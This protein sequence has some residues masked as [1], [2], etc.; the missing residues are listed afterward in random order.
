M[1]IKYK[2]LMLFGKGLIHALAQC[3]YCFTYL[4]QYHCKNP[5]MMSYS[6]G[7]KPI[8]PKPFLNFSF[9]RQVFLSF[10]IDQTRFTSH[11]Q[12]Y[13]YCLVTYIELHL[14]TI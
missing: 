11:I 7:S 4:A 2:L 13:L 10:T 6:T 12:L 3:K 5:A 1:E 14:H 9:V 8:V